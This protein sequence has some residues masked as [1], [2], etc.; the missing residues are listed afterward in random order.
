MNVTTLIVMAHKTVD[1]RLS[2]IHIHLPLHSS[3]VDLRI[4]KSLFMSFITFIVH[5]Y[6]L[7][8]R[9]CYQPGG[10]ALR[11]QMMQGWQAERLVFFL[12]RKHC[13]KRTFR[14]NEIRKS[15]QTETKKLAT[16]S[17]TTYCL[18]KLECEYQFLTRILWALCNLLRIGYM[19]E[20]KDN[21]NKELP[22][23]SSLRLLL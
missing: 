13:S 14:P 7:L 1:Q 16:F 3:P 21:F 9:W 11:L 10:R 12:F 19:Q 22:H 18:Q 20:N 15:V 2:K 5:C 8:I 6:L 23:Y 4:K 17:T